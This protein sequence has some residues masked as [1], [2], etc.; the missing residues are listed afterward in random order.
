MFLRKKNEQSY[1]LQAC[2]DVREAVNFWQATH[3]SERGVEIPEFFSTHPAHSKRAATLKERMPWALDI[4]HQC[5]CSP[6][7]ENKELG[8]VNLPK[9][10][11]DKVLACN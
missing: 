5:N 10:P 6:L 11:G 7:Q 1:F 8:V 3:E 4:R 2:F 9:H